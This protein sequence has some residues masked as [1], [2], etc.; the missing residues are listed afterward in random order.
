M[1]W[2]LAAAAAAMAIGGYFALTR[3][4]PSTP[5][6]TP[7]EISP[8]GQGA[9]AKTSKGKE[10][11]KPGEG[12]WKRLERGKSERLK[13]E[14]MEQ[15][16]ESEREA[17][18]TSRRRRLRERN[19]EWKRVYQPSPACS[20]PNPAWRDV[21]ICANDYIRQRRDFE[22]AWENPKRQEPL[23]NLPPAVTQRK[24]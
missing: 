24:R 9:A 12:S 21:V 11:R 13:Q 19:Q 17:T 1:M 16:L 3:W 7:A 10:P 2:W 8:A 4:V 22:S 5:P 18:A 14:E 6:A 20:V 23:A 15:F